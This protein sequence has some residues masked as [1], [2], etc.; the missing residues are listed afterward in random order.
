[1]VQRPSQGLCVKVS[2][3]GPHDQEGNRKRKSLQMF[4]NERG[5][6][7]RANEAAIPGVVRLVAS[8]TWRRDCPAL[9]L[10]YHGP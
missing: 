4:D 7:V 10:A 8:T 1:M 2:R 6:L 5:A 3:V 9:V